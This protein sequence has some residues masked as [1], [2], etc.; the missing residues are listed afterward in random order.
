M[1]AQRRLEPKQFKESELWYV[2][3]ALAI[4]KQ[5]IK[6]RSVKLGDIK[7]ENIFVNDQGNVKVANIYSWP[8]EHPS[9]YKATDIESDSQ[10]CLLAPEDLAELQRGALD[11]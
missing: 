11:N 3:Y 7:P 1:I 8:N 5:D 2:L 9:F 10:S 6:D 4:A